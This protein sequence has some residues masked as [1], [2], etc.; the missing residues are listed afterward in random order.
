[1]DIS[2]PNRIDGGWKRLIPNAWR[3]GWRVLGPDPQELMCAGRKGM[4]I[5]RPR[6]AAFAPTPPQFIQPNSNWGPTKSTTSPASIGPPYWLYGVARNIRMPDV[7]RQMVSC[8][9]TP[10]LPFLQHR[11]AHQMRCIYRRLGR[12]W[13]CQSDTGPRKRRGVGGKGAALVGRSAH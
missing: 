12:F 2:S 3:G 8:A 9:T 6:D 1:M 13:N 4:S 11:Y 7:R 10:G 5:R